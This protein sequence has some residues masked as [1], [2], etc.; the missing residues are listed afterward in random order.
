VFERYFPRSRPGPE[1]SPPAPSE[2]EAPPPAPGAVA[3]EEGAPEEIAPGEDRPPGRPGGGVDWP[4]AVLAGMVGL[5]AVVFGT[6]TW[7]QQS[8][9]GTFAFDMGIYDQGIW[10][11]SRFKEPFNTVR[12]LN[13][14][15]HHVNLITVAF[16][17]FYWLGA[18]PHFLVVVQTVWM[19][20]GA[21]PVWLLAR[22]RLASPWLALGLAAC[23]LLYPSLEWINWWHFHPDALII[24][25]LLFAWWLATRRRWGRFA[26]AVAVALLCKEDAAFA[27]AA[28]GLALI[29]RGQ[30]RAGVL[31]CLAG[32]GWFLVATKVI[33]PAA[34]GGTS[35]FY[36]RELFPGFGDS[37][38]AIAVNLV[39]HPSRF[40]SAVTKPDV[41]H[42]YWQ[43]LAPVAGMPLAAPEVLLIGIPQAA[44]NSISGHA[45]T[46]DI[47]Y[48]YSSI[49]LAAVFLA[50]VESCAR[51]GTRVVVRRAL[52]GLLVAS[53]LAANVAWSPSPLGVRYDSGIWAAH[54]QRHDAMARA[55]AQVPEGAG[56]SASFHLVPH[57]THRVHVYEFPNPWIPTNWGMRDRPPDPADV[58]YLVLDSTSSTTLPQLFDRLV[59]PGR[60]FE[61]VFDASGIVVAR[62][63]APG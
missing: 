29:L 15:A 20:L 52:V 23:Y 57:L 19:A 13:Y 59:G 12:G 43:M 18:G 28:L 4:V 10:L 21:V 1:G 2:D 42:Y 38:G 17:P 7:R 58:D 31:S 50:T 27:V 25:P 16:V 63:V 40:F 3:L 49:V 56:V 46:H 11:V 32:I 22:D 54:Q 48:H 44:I 5:Y 51:L 6:L 62:R 37:I 35:P 47:R 8:N 53:S 36:V 55:V 45:L 60:P 61:P 9:F 39:S 34:S 30:R 33:I 26:V 41:L 14:F 24:T